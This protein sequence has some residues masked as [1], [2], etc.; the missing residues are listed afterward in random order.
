MWSFL[1]AWSDLL[2]SGSYRKKSKTVFHREILEE[3][4]KFQ[5][6]YAPH[7]IEEKHFD[8]WIFTL[9]SMSVAIFW[10]CLHY[11]EKFEASFQ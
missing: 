7:K 5:E 2:N 11:A 10:G 9:I 3:E 8:F 6:T 4:E 1:K